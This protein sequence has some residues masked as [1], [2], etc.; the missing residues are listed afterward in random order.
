MSITAG[1][2]LEHAKRNKRGRR[3]VGYEDDKQLCYPDDILMLIDA[4]AEVVRVNAKQVGGTYRH[5]VVFDGHSFV[6]GSSRKVPNLR[7]YE[8]QH[9]N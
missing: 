2:L 1:E 3:D 7:P 6:A 9:G 8:L 5:D 4:G